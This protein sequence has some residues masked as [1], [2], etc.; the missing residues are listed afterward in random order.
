MGRPYGGFL[1]CVFPVGGARPPQPLRYSQS[2]TFSLE[3]VEEG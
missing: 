3:K 1:F 2:H